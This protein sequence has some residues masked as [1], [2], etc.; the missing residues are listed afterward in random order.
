MSIPFHPI[1]ED[2]FS[3][4]STRTMRAMVRGRRDRG[5]RPEAAG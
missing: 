2:L 5:G 4:G 1:M 3:L